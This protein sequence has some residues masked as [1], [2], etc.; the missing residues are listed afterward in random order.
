MSYID[1]ERS[2][3]AL[4]NRL[5][6]LRNLRKSLVNEKDNTPIVEVKKEYR[7]IFDMFICHAFMH[8][9]NRYRK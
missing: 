6:Y 9:K 7:Q 5:I 4:R 1:H 8:L 3:K 2:A